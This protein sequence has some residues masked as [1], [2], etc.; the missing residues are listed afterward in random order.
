MDKAR[1]V[2]VGGEQFFLLPIKF[3][4]KAAEVAIHRD[5]ATGDVILAERKPSWDGFDAHP[6]LADVPADFMDDREQG[7]QDRDP[8]DGWDDGDCTVLS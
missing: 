5:D 4:F 7:V 1:L 8:L 2:W 3:R 6:G